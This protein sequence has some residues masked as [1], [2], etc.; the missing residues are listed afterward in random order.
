MNKEIFSEMKVIVVDCRYLYEFE[1][2]HIETA[3][4]VTD[5]SVLENMFFNGILEG[6]K[7]DSKLRENCIIVFHCEFSHKRGPKMYSN[8][9]IIKEDK[10]E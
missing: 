1:G 5:P 4:N 7:E 9:Y 3:M 8:F 10:F 2:G 6:N